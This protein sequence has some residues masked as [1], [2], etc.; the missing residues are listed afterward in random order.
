MDSQDCY[1]KD[2][3]NCSGH[4]AGGFV[5]VK[6]LW[7]ASTSRGDS[8][9]EELSE[10][11]DAKYWCHKNCVSSYTSKSHIKVEV[12]KKGD[13]DAPPAKQSRRSEQDTFIFKEHCFLCGKPCEELDPCHPDWWWPVSYCRTADHGKSQKTFK[14]V[15]LD[16]CDHRNDEWGNQV[17]LRVQAAVSD[18]HVADAKYQRLSA[19]IQK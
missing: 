8:L 3:I 15:I 7:I 13:N 4:G 6:Q 2:Y 16:T 9:H 10:E 17:R 12:S 19:V 18:F 1:L 5:G 11:P 14:D